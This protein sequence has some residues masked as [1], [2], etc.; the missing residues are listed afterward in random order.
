MLGNLQDHSITYDE[1]LKRVWQLL[2]HNAVRNGAPHCD[3]ED[4]ASEV[5]AGILN[6]PRDLAFVLRER[7]RIH[8][9]RLPGKLALRV[10]EE[11]C[12][13]RAKCVK[14][15]DATNLDSIA[16]AQ[17]QSHDECGRL[18]AEEFRA[19]L[20]PKFRDVLQLQIDGFTQEQMAVRLGISE[21]TVR[22]LVAAIRMKAEGACLKPSWR[23]HTI[24]SKPKVE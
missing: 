13:M 3:A 14:R 22:N 4:A 11:I 7:E 16:R 12:Q 9:G 1:L 6:R 21:R 23:R 10:V 8:S 20:S 24:R 17:E 18:A 2:F 15:G 19:S 5:L